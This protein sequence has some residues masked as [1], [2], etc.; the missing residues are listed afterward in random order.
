M[1]VLPTNL[2]NR[3]KPRW[4]LTRSEASIDPALW[5]KF[6]S[7]DKDK[8]GKLTINEYRLYASK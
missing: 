3:Q 2:K 6:V 7:Y 4:F 1:A 5:S 8:D